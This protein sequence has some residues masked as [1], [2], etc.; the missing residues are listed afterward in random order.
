MCSECM[1]CTE[2]MECVVCMVCMC[3]CVHLR[4]HGGAERISLYFLYCSDCL[5]NEIKT[6]C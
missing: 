5:K 3:A 4:C 1:E 6:E 2:C